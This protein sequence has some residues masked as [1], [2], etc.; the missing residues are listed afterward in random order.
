MSWRLLPANWTRV[1][2][3]HL[4]GDRFLDDVA[5]AWHAAER[6]EARHEN[7]M[8]LAY[9]MADLVVVGPARRP[10]QNF[11]QWDASLLIPSPYVAENHKRPMQRSSTIW[12]AEVLVEQGDEYSSSAVDEHHVRSGRASKHGDCGEGVACLDAAVAAADIV[13]RVLSQ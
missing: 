4:C 3:L 2:M 1:R 10:W 8:G 5:S 9:A 6:G 12:A 7:Q 11:A 13:E